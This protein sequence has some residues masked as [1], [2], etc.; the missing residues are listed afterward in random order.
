MKSFWTEH[1]GCRFLYADYSNYGRN[2]EALRLELDYADTMIENEPRNDTLVLVDIRHTVTSTP[3]VSLMKESAARTKGRVAKLA[4][5][6]VSGVQRILA[7]AVSRFSRE[8]LQLFD[9]LDAAKDWLVEGGEG[10][11]RIAAE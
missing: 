9:D 8:P 3:V 7:T 6:G 1:K 10:G 2:L 5:I 11:R 4:V